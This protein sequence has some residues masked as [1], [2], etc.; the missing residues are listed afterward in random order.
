MRRE[1]AIKGLTRASKTVL[2]TSAAE[3]QRKGSGRGK[4]ARGGTGKPARK[5]SVRE[6]R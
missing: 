3:S 6:K 1:R 5:P 4:K 2:I